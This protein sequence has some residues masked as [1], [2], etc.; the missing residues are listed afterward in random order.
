MPTMHLDLY[1]GGA[2]HDKQKERH[3]IHE[4]GHALGLR[5]EH[6]RSD[7]WA[8]IRPYIDVNKMKRDVQAHLGLSS[9]SQEDQE[10]FVK[11]WDANFEVDGKV[12]VGDPD[13]EYD[14]KSIMHYP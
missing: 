5:H 13:S 3:V 4:F 10:Q 14:A 1:Q 7:F 9:G 11:F 2:I 6:Q 8:C 12:N